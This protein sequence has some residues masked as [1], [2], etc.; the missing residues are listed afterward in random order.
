M[1]VA[2]TLEVQ[3]L[4]NLARLSSDMNKAKSMVGGA[5]KNIEGA[6]AS[7]K[8]A[9]GALGIGLG[10]GAFAAFIKRTIDAADAL[11]DLRTRTGLTGQELLVL[12][13][14]AARSGVEMAAVGDIATRMTSRLTDAARGTGDAAEGYR[15]LGM[16]VK[17]SSGSF[18]S[19]FQILTEA[20]AK[21]REFEDGP[22][23]AA[24]AIAAFGKGGDRL[25][26]MI[27]AIEETR[28]RLQRLG[29]T[30]DDDFITKADAFNDKIEDMRAVQGVLARQFTA[31]LL[32]Y[33]DKFVDILILMTQ[34]TDGMAVAVQAIVGPLKVM[35]TGFVALGGAIASTGEILAAFA[36]AVNTRFAQQTKALTDYFEGLKSFDL[37]KMID[38][39]GRLMS[40]DFKDF[41]GE[42]SI[43]LKRAETTAQNTANVISK[44]WSDVPVPQFVGPPESARR[45][46]PAPGMPDLKGMKASADAA[47]AAAD[48]E[49]RLLELQTR[50]KLEALKDAAQ[51]E[52]ELLDMAH[53]DS[54]ISDKNY[55]SQRL[56]IQRGA[57]QAELA[58]INEQIARQEEAAKLA[59]KG[60]KDYFNALGDLAESQAKR[61]K[62]ESEFGQFAVKNYLEAA[63]AADN[64]RRTVLDLD[65]Q[66]A[67]L[68]GNDVDATRLRLDLQNEQL[69]R[70]FTVNNDT[71]AL[72]KLDEIERLT[73]EQAR[74]NA[75]R[76]KLSAINTRLG[77]QESHIQTLQRTGAISELE[78]LRQ[79]EAA[80]K[81]QLGTMEAQVIALENIAK[82]A[83]NLSNIMQAE[84][85]RAELENLRLESNLV[86]QKFDSIFSDSLSNAFNDFISGAKTAKEAMNDFGNAVVAQVNRLIIDDLSKKLFAGI[87]GEAGFGIGDIFAGLFGSGAKPQSGITGVAS[88]AAAGPSTIGAGDRGAEAF[89]DVLASSGAGLGSLGIGATSANTAL[90]SF[91]ITTGVANTAL[92]S[93]AS[94]A[95][96]AATALSSM[97]ASSAMGGA[98]AAGA[99]P[100]LLGSGS[101]G[102][103]AFAGVAAAAGASFATG[104]DYVPRTG[105]ALVHQGERIIPASENKQGS[106]RPLRVI[107]NFTISGAVDKRSQGQIAAEAG[108][109]VRKAMSRNG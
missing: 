55:Y 71:A 3:M 44:I 94:A 38:A 93:L 90:S 31:V 83:P 18:K 39:A 74:F 2:G 52:Q 8:S 97:G 21:F 72:G 36:F 61:N 56:E 92:T 48:A 15:A 59:P 107:N 99:F 68:R 82:A 27:E 40:M 108:K 47:R 91:G 89:A 29:V 86:A 87:K 101:G 81:A 32:P 51:R 104:T 14:A 80:R 57:F 24:I 88:A 85:A 35:A 62:L 45:R 73:M 10:V 63:R 5:M 46:R 22:N 19:I 20:G 23:K 69:R 34:K 37:S 17:N 49:M 102:A 75:E 43:G 25:I 77:I 67:S 16:E 11:N 7:A 84:Q 96:M 4:A 78:A 60:T 100:M 1:A 105:L 98:S 66:L 76:E 50:L 41:G 109:G 28:Q 26:P 54:L 12:Q 70:Q 64:Y 6:V 103:S 42:M 30:I 79:T 33:L 13:G 106:Q 9:L 58:V 53:Q 65:A 95:S